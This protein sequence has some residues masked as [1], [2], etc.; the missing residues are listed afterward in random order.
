MKH[1]AWLLVFVSEL[2]FGQ[3]FK[4]EITKGGWVGIVTHDGHL[5][6][7]VKTISLS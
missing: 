6:K 7:I 4:I 3:T 1:L 5:D 2:S